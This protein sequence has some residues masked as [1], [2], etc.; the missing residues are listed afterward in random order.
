[1]YDIYDNILEDFTDIPFKLFD[2]IGQNHKDMD[3]EEEYEYDPKK[4][5]TPRKKSTN[6][7]IIQTQKN[8]WSRRNVL[9]VAYAIPHFAGRMG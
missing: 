9:I 6:C 7:A 3:G 8:F 1:M 5:L 4:N 2:R